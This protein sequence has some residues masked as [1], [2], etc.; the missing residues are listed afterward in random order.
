[1]RHTAT[2]ILEDGGAGDTSKFGPS[3]S[4]DGRTI[5]Y[6]D[7]IGEDGD[8]SLYDVATKTT[9]DLGL[10]TRGD[11]DWAPD[12]TKLTF[13]GV[14]GSVGV[15]DLANRVVRRLVATATQA[16]W[17]PDGRLIVFV[18]GSGDASELWLAR[19][20]GTHARRLTHD[21]FPELHPTWEPL[22]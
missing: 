22:G 6:V 19:S 11:I 10:E 5:A 3:W 1:V 13:D 2:Q 4:P 7:G 14:D 16:A 12:A 8:L 15:A 20:D 18:R 9:R 21:R 17:S